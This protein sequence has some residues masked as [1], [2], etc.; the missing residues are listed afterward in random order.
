[1]FQKK[2][3]NKKKEIQEL[4]QLLEE[5]SLKM[6]KSNYG[7]SWEVIE[8]AFRKIYKFKASVLSY[9][10]IYRT[11]Y[12]LVLGKQADILY[13]KINQYICDHAKNCSLHISDLQDERYLSE[14]SNIWEKYLIQHQ[15]IHDLFLYLDRTYS[16]KQ[17]KKHVY[18][19]SIIHWKKQVLE[20]SKIK[21]KIVS[22]VSQ[23]I[24]K[25]R[26]GEKIYSNS[27]KII[28]KMFIAVSEKELTF[29]EKEYEDY[30]L[31]EMVSYYKKESQAVLENNS[32]ASYLFYC[33]KRLLEENERIL[34]YYD[35]TSKNRI[36]T[37]CERELLSNHL[38]MI[39]GMETGCL[40]MIKQDKYEELKLLYTL[41]VRIPHGR[42]K[43]L[44]V[45]IDYFNLL[46]NETIKESATNK[47]AS[48]QLIDNLLKLRG[49]FE[50]ILNQS[51]LNDQTIKIKFNKAF[52]IILNKNEKIPEYLVRYIDKSFRISFK[53]YH[54]VKKIMDKVIILLNL[55]YEKDVFKKFYE[56]YLAKRLLL[57]KNN[58]INDLERNMITKIKQEY[59]AQY[60]SKME[61]MFKDMGLSYEISNKF[62]QYLNEK[63][64]RINNSNG[65]A[66]SNN[67]KVG[68]DIN[69][70]ADNK[71]EK[72]GENSELILKN[73]YQKININIKIL[74]QGHWPTFPTQPCLLNK[75]LTN[76]CNEFEVFYLGMHTG[77]VIVWQYNIGSAELQFNLQNKRYLLIVSTHQMLIL[78]SFN[79]RPEITLEELH[80]LTNISFLNLQKSLNALLCGKNKILI[81]NGKPN[82]ILNKDILSINLKF[83]SKM[84]RIKIPSQL[85]PDLHRNREK[86]IQKVNHDRKLL[87][88]ATVVRIMKA[89]KILNHSNLIIEIT[90]QLNHLFNPKINLIKQRMEHLI[91][92]EYLERTQEDRNLYKYVA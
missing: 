65:K 28:A 1:M 9:E 52:E 42:E 7:N 50:K 56:S 88:D 82:E 66:I 59:G 12:D 74:A 44:K 15:M 13:D 20:N 2:N 21:E 92:Q 39:I 19:L 49:R 57:Q 36:L 76:Y 41:L 14:T 86:T 45:Y 27:I 34:H 53:G 54:E 89:R 48:L 63:G 68:N 38:D 77:R 18:G 72:G 47:K 67:V 6:E 16:E 31:N 85:N 60:T 81:K 55:L 83:K 24:T 90:K 71:N 46:G 61:G 23:L 37:S 58:Q 30:L 62:L 78:E 91:Q 32:C 26:N 22:L 33:Q 87:I 29:Y 51:F 8:K 3:K 79:H 35:P 40:Q 5:T 4:N 84:R 64:I 80:Q 69:R 75:Y 10:E 17:K 70:N 11:S 25:E 43:I 73:E